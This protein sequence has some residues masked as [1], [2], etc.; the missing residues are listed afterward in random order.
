MEGGELVLSSAAASPPPA[1]ITDPS[2]FHSLI[3]DEEHHHDLDHDHEEHDHEHD[4]DE[5]QQVHDHVV[6]NDVSLDDLKI[7]I[8]KQVEYYFSDENLPTDKYLLGYVKRNKEGFV[9]ISVIASFRKMKKL[10][11]DYSFIVAA[12]KESS[13]LAV[14]GDCKRVKRLNPQIQFRDN[15]LY[16]VL[17]EN[18]PEDHSKENIHRIFNEA[19]NIKRITIHDPRPTAEAAKHIKQ[20]KFISNKL[21]ALVEYETIEAA[22]KAVAMLNDEQDWRNG[23]HVKPLKRMG[24]QGHSKQT[25]K[26]STAAEKNSSSHVSEHKGDEGNHSS[27]E[28]HEDTHDEEDGEHLPKDTGRQGYRNQGRSRK[29][30]YRAINGMGHGSNPSTHAAEASKPP[31]GP[32]M[33]DGTRGFAVGRGRPPVPPPN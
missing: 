28:H 12:L 5:E 30:K 23:M 1:E 2:E 14:S 21:H 16:T 19:G 31:P 6:D 33:P 8:L 22:E 32:R 20:E 24:K 27:N 10:T 7:K 11:R 25:W 9:P 13:L 18:L 17:V 3:S 15:K 26:A 29:H 4:L